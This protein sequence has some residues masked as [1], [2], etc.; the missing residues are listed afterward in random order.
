MTWIVIFICRLATWRGTIFSPVIEL[1]HL[2]HSLFPLIHLC[3]IGEQSIYEHL[4]LPRGLNMLLQHISHTQ[5]HFRD[6]LPELLFARMHRKNKLKRRLH[7]NRSTYFSA[8][9]NTESRKE[10]A[11]TTYCMN[12]AHH[13]FVV[14]T[15]ILR[16]MST[17]FCECM[18]VRL[19]IEFW[20]GL[21]SSL[22]SHPCHNVYIFVSPGRCTR[23]FVTE[24]WKCAVVWL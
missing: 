24:R 16:M 18:C 14:C 15:V 19:W 9:A 23:V 21:L 6:R 13:I 5:S 2:F 1:L 4:F 3:F 7:L 17:T 10:V 12:T 22:Q 11:M 20:W 8:I